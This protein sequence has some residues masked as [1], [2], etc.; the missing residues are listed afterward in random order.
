MFYDNGDEN[1]SSTS[2]RQAMSAELITIRAFAYP[3]Q[4]RNTDKQSNLGNVS[5]QRLIN[6]SRSISTLSSVCPVLREILMCSKIL[7]KL[8]NMNF[9]FRMFGRR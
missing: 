5:N 8:F 9:T 7:T 1:M 3:W 2:T 6:V 4:P